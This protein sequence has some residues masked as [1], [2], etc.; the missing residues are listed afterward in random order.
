MDWSFNGIVIM[1]QNQLS[2][3]S[4]WASIIYFGVYQRI[5]D[6]IAYGLYQLL[7]V[8]QFYFRESFWTTAQRIESLAKECFLLGYVP[9]RKQGAIG[10]IIIST[11]SGFSTSNINNLGNIIIPKWSI[12][13]NTS[14]TSKV[15][16]N[17]ATTYYK[18]TVGNQTVTVTEGTPKTYLYQAQG[19]SSEIIYLYA[20]D[21]THGIE[22][23]NFDVYIADSAGNILQQVS[24]VENLYFISDLTS[25]YCTVTNAY[26]FAYVAITFGD[27]IT[28]T[29]LQP[30]Q[31]V[32]IKY[33]ET[34]GDTGNIQSTG[35]IT[36]IVS[37]LYDDLGNDLTT[38]LYITNTEEITGGTDF[39][40]IESIRNN[41]PNLFQTGYR[42]G[43]H[44][45]ILAIIESAPYVQTA[46]TWTVNDIGGSTLLSDQNTNYVSV[47]TTDGNDVT[48][49]EQTDLQTNYLAKKLALTDTIT[50]QPLSMIYAFFQVTAKISNLTTAQ[51]SSI[52]KDT[53]Y[54]TYNS[55][56]VPFQQNIY[57]SQYVTTISSIPYVVYHNTTLYN[58]EKNISKSVINGTIATSYTSSNTTDLTDQVLMVNDTFQ[59]WINQKINNTWT[60]PWQ[61]AYSSGT[62]LYN[63]MPNSFTIT[64]GSVSPTTNQYTFALS[65][66]TGSGVLETGVQNPEDNNPNG[67][68]VSIAYQTV[69]GN[70]KN[71]NCIRLPYLYQ[72]TNVDQDFITTNISY[73]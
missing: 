18:T 51:M 31:Y 28:V 56:V 2:L 14:G 66:Y 47:L 33:A 7:Y 50:W 44:N 16:S 1:L 3:F 43:T 21:T 20:S 57:E 27:G 59:V 5:I 24:V 10:N 9:Y 22:N 19:V 64:L 13:Q 36:K 58:L 32:L 11:D 65:S 67:Y 52:I 48:N 15:Y 40:D 38:S 72:I 17:T 41:A 73:I 42:A 34:S 37:T 35:A 71:N 30:N 60:G 4:N 23:N 55:L 54:D 25:Y 45:D 8:A 70:G 69:D 39:E 29:Q 6:V 12:F 46:Q 62:N 49:T 68:I 61:I 53:L 63:A 26:D